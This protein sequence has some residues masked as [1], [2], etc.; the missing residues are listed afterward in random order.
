[1]DALECA[2]A[3]AVGE[4]GGCVSR[5]GVFVRRGQFEAKEKRPALP[6]QTLKNPYNTYKNTP[7]FFTQRCFHLELMTRIELVN[8]ILTKDALY[9]LSYISAATK[10]IIAELFGFDKPFFQIF[11]IFLF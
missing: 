4:E 10:R 5:H 1:M 6:G 9:R 8:L 3:R 11:L 7:A 2:R